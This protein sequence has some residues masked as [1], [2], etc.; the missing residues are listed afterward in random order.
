MPTCTICGREKAVLTPR[1]LRTARILGKQEQRLAH[2]VQTTTTYGEFQEHHYAVCAGCIR[3]WDRIARSVALVFA[4]AGTIALITASIRVHQPW[5]FA[6]G[7]VFLIV[8]MAPVS[9]LNVEAKLSKRALRERG[10]AIRGIHAFMFTGETEHFKAFNDKE[11]Q[12][13]RAR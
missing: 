8:G 5:F 9:H 12:A 3:T 4:I 6:G 11:Y 2:A 1:T 13:L 10:E 7:L